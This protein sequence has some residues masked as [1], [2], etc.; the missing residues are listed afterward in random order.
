MQP[1]NQSEVRNNPGPSHRPDWSPER[2]NRPDVRPPDFRPP[3]PLIQNQPTGRSSP[4]NSQVQ[5]LPPSADSYTLFEPQ[6]NVP[7]VVNDS[8]SQT[9]NSAFHNQIL[10]EEGFQI[11]EKLRMKKFHLI[12]S[13][14]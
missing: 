5:T 8:F 14:E 10:T 12:L 6:M 4:Q 2:Q 11:N 9:Q 7:A 3:S 1:I 13:R